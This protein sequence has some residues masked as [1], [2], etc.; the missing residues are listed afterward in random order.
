[1]GACTPLSGA[2]HLDVVKALLFQIERL[3]LAHH[4]AIAIEQVGLLLGQIAKGSRQLEEGDVQNVAPFHHQRL[5]VALI[6]GADVQDDFVGG[7]HLGGLHLLHLGGS[8]FA[9]AANVF[10][11]V[12]ENKILFMAV[13]MVFLLAVGTSMDL[14]PT[15]LIFGPVCAPLAI[16][17]GIDPVYFGFMFIYVGCLGL[18]TP[19]VGTVQNVVAGVGK[20]RMETVIKGTNPF[21]MVYV[22]LAALFVIFGAS[23]LMRAL[24]KK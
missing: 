1:M 11:P 13:M 20:L 4:A 2:V 23:L 5:L 7:Q 3:Q 12:M 8:L 24:F 16:K 17:A 22:V 18:I 6:T 15:I 19:P 21:L 14:T 10:G 9:D